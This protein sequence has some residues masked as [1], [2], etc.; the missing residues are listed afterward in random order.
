MQKLKGYRLIYFLEV[1]TLVYQQPSKS[2]IRISQNSI[3][4]LVPLENLDKKSTCPQFHISSLDPTCLCL[5]PL[6]W[7]LLEGRSS[8]FPGNAFPEKWPTVTEILEP[9]LRQHEY[10]LW[11]QQEDYIKLLFPLDSP[12][13]SE[14]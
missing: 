6:F 9:S 7:P 14:V 13:S 1:I 8:L 5:S 3:C 11:S 4:H 12:E 10:G 2:R